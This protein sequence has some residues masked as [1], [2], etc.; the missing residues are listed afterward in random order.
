[1]PWIQNVSLEDVRKG[2]HRADGNLVLIQISDS[3]MEF[4][5]PH[6]EFEKVYQFHFF[7]LERDDDVPDEEMKITD[8]Q[9]KE[10]VDI[11]RESLHNNYN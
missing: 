10:L 7:D 8:D 6:H 5:V 11:L 1:M 9:A 3:D 2:D 4:P